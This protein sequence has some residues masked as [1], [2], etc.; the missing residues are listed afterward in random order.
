MPEGSRNDINEE[1]FVEPDL[2]GFQIGF[3]PYLNK[4]FKR[5]QLITYMKRMHF[6]RSLAMVIKYRPLSVKDL[7]FN[8][9]QM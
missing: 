6:Q 4:A 9:S 5:T 8:G 3:E 2:E 7:R 1:R